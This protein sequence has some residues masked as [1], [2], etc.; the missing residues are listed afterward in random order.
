M[1]AHSEPS[2]WRNRTDEVW[3]ACCNEPGLV[4]LIDLKHMMHSLF[5]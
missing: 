4:A 5:V 1:L 3:K 2:H